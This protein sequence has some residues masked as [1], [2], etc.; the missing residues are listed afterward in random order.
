MQFTGQ[1]FGVTCSS[2][3]TGDPWKWGCD[4]PNVWL[5]DGG[6]ASAATA[7]Q[8]AFLDN[9][10]L[11]DYGMTLGP[12]LDLD[13]AN[14]Y[15]IY[16]LTA[17]YFAVPAVTGQL[18]LGAKAGASGMVTNAIGGIAT[19]SGRAAG[20]AFQGDIVQRIK[21]N[22]ESVGQ[23]AYAKEMG[24]NG[25]Y[26]QHMSARTKAFDQG[27]RGA[28]ASAQAQGAGSKKEM[29]EYTQKMEQT[30]LQ[31]GRA[32]WSATSDAVFG[33]ADKRKKGVLPALKEDADRRK[34]NT[35]EAVEAAK[36]A[37]K[38]K[39]G[40]GTKQAVKD[41][42]ADTKASGGKK[43]GGDQLQRG[44]TADRYASNAN[45]YTDQLSAGEGGVGEGE[46]ARILNAKSNLPKDLMQSSAGLFQDLHHAA[47]SDS[48]MR[49]GFKAQAEYAGEA[50]GANVES[51]E[52]QQ[53]SSRYERHAG[54]LGSHANFKAASAAWRA[55]N[56]YGNRMGA[57]ATA[58]GLFAGGL[59]A[60]PKPIDADGMAMSGMVGQGNRAKANHWSDSWTS[61][62][63][64]RSGAARGDIGSRAGALKSNYGRDAVQDTYKPISN[65]DALINSLEAIPEFLKNNVTATRSS[66]SQ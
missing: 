64:Q 49:R 9:I 39:P 20:S 22:Q 32:A 21:S 12:N 66:L 40:G 47:G 31:T 27:V 51:F 52:A 60:G 24:S 43:P 10:Q 48:V 30:A 34:G 44:N 2:S 54:M 63:K 14:G 38:K 42:V 37:G 4:V 25:I 13:L 29:R 6:I 8:A 17:L 28:H 11:F 53:T 7:G 45:E 18:V 26:S 50:A 46:N 33:N 16:I 5:T 59:D 61:G 41:G 57:T 65:R 35:P 19:E 56:N 55:K 3:G 15:Y 58:L 1:S 23:A 36:T 62:G